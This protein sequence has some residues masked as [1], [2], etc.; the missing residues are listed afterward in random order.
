MRFSMFP[1]NPWGWFD[2][3]MGLL[4][5]FYGIL[6][7]RQRNADCFG[8][9]LNLTF[10]IHGYS[11]YFNGPWKNEVL[12]WISLI[13]KVGFDGYATFTTQ[14]RCLLQLKYSSKVPYVEEFRWKGQINGDV[15]KKPDPLSDAGKKELEEIKELADSNGNDPSTWD[16]MDDV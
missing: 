3:F 10:S 1:N 6:N 8:R 9:M 16:S 12:A 5:G 7:V 13:L 4:V 11:K 15:N 14:K 2:F